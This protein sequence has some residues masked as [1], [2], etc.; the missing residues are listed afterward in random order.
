MKRKDRDELDDLFRSKL[1]DFE[2]DALSDDVWDKIEGRL[3]KQRHIVPAST[4]WKWWTAAAAVALLILGSAVYY[5]QNEPTIDPVLVQEIEQKSEELKS[6]IQEQER[7]ATPAVSE[8]VSPVIAQARDRKVAVANNTVMHNV[9]TEVIAPV[10]EIAFQPESS[11][12]SS[13]AVSVDHKTEEI[14]KI[15]QN[16]PVLKSDIEEGELVGQST[17][18]KRWSFGMGAGSLSAGSKDAA[19]MYAFRNT[20]LENSELDFINS[21]GDKYMSVEPKTDIKH[22]QPISFGLSASYM[23]TP[24][25]YLMAG[26]SYSFVASEWKT[27]GSYYTS[28]EQRLHFVGLPVSLAYKIAEWN[29]FMWYASAG[30]KPEVNVAGTIE[31]KRY[32]NGQVMGKPE[33]VNQRIN[34]W[35][36]S[37]NAGTGVSYPLL[38]FLSAYAE[39]GA[40]YYFDNGTKIETI[41]SDKPFNVNLSV[42]LRLGF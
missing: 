23:L 40:G 41:Y 28:T 32:T 10:E 39:V 30:F 6:T 24:R 3:N 7:I 16:E 14:V 29:R 36:W 27:N 8:P 37:V 4:R 25:W 31:E 11:Q 1:Y 5:L 35:Y 15:Q 20:S 38:R 26:V 13:D 33:K 12:D 42:G 22:K 17:K 34:E 19:N 2:P 21:F 9:K 18:V